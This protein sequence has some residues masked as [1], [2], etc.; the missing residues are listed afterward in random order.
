MQLHKYIELDF[1]ENTSRKAMS[2]RKN[3]VLSAALGSPDVVSVG[4]SFFLG[5]CVRGLGRLM[6]LRLVL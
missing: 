3:K 5:I 6:S 2:I 4:R 1:A